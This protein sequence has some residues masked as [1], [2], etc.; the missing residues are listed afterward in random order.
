[1][2]PW[3]GEP[4]SH[5]QPHQV[6]GQGRKGLNNKCMASSLHRQIYADSKF[7]VALW[8]SAQQHSTYLNIFLWLPG[9]PR[10]F[11]AKVVLM[12]RLMMPHVCQEGIRSCVTCI[13]RISGE[14]RHPSHSEMT[15]AKRRVRWLQ[16]LLQSKG[17]KDWVCVVWTCPQHPG[18]EWVHFLVV[19]PRDEGGWGLKAVSQHQ[20]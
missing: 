19:L 16:F 20:K 9:R 10:P 5:H 6:P 3:Q 1:M 8:G 18:K 17:E 11:P 13:M 7:T 2:L 14:N 12:L 15:W 4:F